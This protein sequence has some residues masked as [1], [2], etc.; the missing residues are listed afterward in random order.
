MHQALNRC[1]FSIVVDCCHKKE[2][3]Q[4]VIGHVTGILYATLAPYGRGK[5][6]VYMYATIGSSNNRKISIMHNYIEAVKSYVYAA[7]SLTYPT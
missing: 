1:Y 5:Q 6:I 4:H 2:D 3:I 7:G